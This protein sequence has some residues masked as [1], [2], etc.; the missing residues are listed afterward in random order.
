MRAFLILCVAIFTLLTFYSAL[1]FKSEDIQTDITN[2]VTDDLN[3]QGAKDVAIDVDGRHVTLSGVVYDEATETAYLDTAN[4]TYGALGPI[5]GLTYVS[6]GGF[7]KAIKNDSGIT[8][9]GT[10]PS[11]EARDQ[12]VAKAGEATD[13]DVTDNLTIGG[14]A[15]DW[16]G[17][18]D[19]GVSKLADLSQGALAVAPGSY[20]LSGMAMGDAAPLQSDLSGRDGWQSFVSSPAVEADLSDEVKRLQA[21]ASEL[22]TERDSLTASLAAVNNDYASAKNA[23]DAAIA[24][25]AGL[26][27]E[28]DGLIAERDTAIGERDTARTD[29]ANLRASLDDN[30]STAASLAA[31]LDAANTGI[32]ERDTTIEG[33][34]GQ[35][36]DLTTAKDDLTAANTG[37]TADNADLTAKLEAQTAALS[38]DEQEAASLQTK[39]DVQTATI[40]GLTADLDAMKSSASNLGSEGEAAKAKI[41]DLEGELDAAKTQVTTLEGQLADQANAGNPE[42]DAKIAALTADLGTQTAQAETL[43]KQVDDLT[44]TVAERDAT[45]VSLQNAAPVTTASAPETAQQCSARAGQIL[46]VAQINFSS[47]TANIS[48]RSVATLERLTG[49]AIACADS[50]LKM[51]IGGHTDS[52]GSDANNQTLSERRAN[53]V[54]KFMSDRGVPADTLTAVGYGEA[55]PIGD[56]AT[57]AGRAKNRRISFE[58]QAR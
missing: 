58:W 38:V 52:Q 3:A 11:E 35:I 10:V 12:L 2:R 55:Q 49:I 5:D 56:N 8:L 13:G 22:T 43:G 40:R 29:L 28:R 26:T 46:E 21:D 18:A 31:D 33:L 53:A 51:E 19:Y 17:E 15:G 45:I 41:A 32:A 9:S 30:Q 36:A 27:I 24:A 50:G 34:N 44:A 6:G 16:Q 54:A 20:T 25:S 23:R 4:D 42:L 37:L 39:I 47:G 1:W 57:P 14:A 48:N 7:I